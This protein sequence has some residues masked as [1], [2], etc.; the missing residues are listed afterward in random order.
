VENSYTDWIDAI[1]SAENKP[2]IWQTWNSKSNSDAR[3]GA[4]KVSLLIVF[5]S[6]LFSSDN[7]QN[8]KSYPRL[9]NNINK[10]KLGSIIKHNHA[11]YGYGADP[12]STFMCVA[13]NN[14]PVSGQGR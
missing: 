3:M 11:K 6:F 10:V 7:A 9:S 13:G 5:F 2:M 8:A 14:R 1:A 4:S 12:A